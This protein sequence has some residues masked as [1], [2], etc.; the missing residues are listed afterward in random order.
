MKE[1]LTADLSAQLD[2][3]RCLKIH[4][5]CVLIQH[6][7]VM[8]P[9][10]NDSEWSLKWYL[11]VSR[12]CIFFILH[13]SAL[14]WQ[15]QKVV[16]ARERENKYTLNHNYRCVPEHPRGKLVKWAEEQS[17]GGKGANKAIYRHGFYPFFCCQGSVN[18]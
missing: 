4:R 10:K 7:K 5:S 12:R 3:T 17:K 16:T 13:S 15:R 9:L 11:L 6:L 18:L 14:F 2:L 1:L 8:I